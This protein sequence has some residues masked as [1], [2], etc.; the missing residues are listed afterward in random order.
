MKTLARMCSA[1][2]SIALLWASAI[3]ASA[4]LGAGDTMTFLILP[5]LG[6]ASVMQLRHAHTA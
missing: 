1:S 5:V 2:T 4:I 6:V 3:L